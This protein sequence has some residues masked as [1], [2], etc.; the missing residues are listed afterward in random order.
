MTQELKTE[1]A[2]IIEWL[3]TDVKISRFHFIL[4][5]GLV[6]ILLLVLVNQLS[7]LQDIARYLEQIA[8]GNLVF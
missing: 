6:A 3:K 7:T 5:L 1:Q 2:P 4:L 8:S